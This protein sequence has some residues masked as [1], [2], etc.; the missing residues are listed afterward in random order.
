NAQVNRI[1]IRNGCAVGVAYQGKSGHEI[2]AFATNEVLICSGAM[3]SAKLL[4]LSGIGPEEHLS[5]LGIDTVA[6]LP[7]GKNFHDHL[8][9]SINVTT[10]QPI[11][12]FGADQGLN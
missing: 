1:I 4:M 10:K 5:S 12:L 7:V 11:S 9:M 3:G 6:N 8:H 2:E